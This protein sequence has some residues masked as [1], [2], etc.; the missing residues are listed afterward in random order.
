MYLMSDCNPGKKFPSNTIVGVDRSSADEKR[1][2]IKISDDFDESDSS[3]LGDSG[4]SNN[5]GESNVW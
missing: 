1:V 4:E 3:E 5:S 2:R